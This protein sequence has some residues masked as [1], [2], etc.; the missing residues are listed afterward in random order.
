MKTAMIA[1][2]LAASPAAAAKSCSDA[3]AAAGVSDR[4]AETVAHAVHSLTVQDLQMFAPGTTEDNNI[5]TVPHNLTIV[6]GKVPPISHNAPDTPLP[7]GFD[8]DAMRTID[9][10][11]SH[12]GEHNDG[13]G[14]V[15]SSLE[16]VVHV[17]HMKDL[18][19][20]INAAVSF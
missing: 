20:R 3:Y 10:V 13:L 5:P 8:T 18:W 2:A 16:R 1:L 7:T 11:L 14:D 15:W 12:L 17:F 4:F 6:D 9:G 19:Y